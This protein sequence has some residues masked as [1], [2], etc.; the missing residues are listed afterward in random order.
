[1][2]IK[3]DG[4]RGVKRISLI[5]VIIVVLIL[6][7]VLSLYFIFDL[8]NKQQEIIDQTMKGWQLRCSK[9][10]VFETSSNFASCTD[11]ACVDIAAGIQKCVCSDNKKNWYKTKCVE[12]TKVIPVIY[13]QTNK[14]SQ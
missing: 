9:T 1:M 6:A 4:P 5:K 8:R 10:E 3:E 2:K 11:P 14:T 12:A 7:Q 13:E